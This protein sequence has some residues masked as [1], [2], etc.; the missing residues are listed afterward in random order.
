MN[1]FHKKITSPVGLLT[2]VASDEALVAIL[3]DADKPSRIRPAIGSIDNRHPILNDAERQLG[4]YFR[5]EREAFELP[6]DPAGTDF[7]KRVWLA[8]RKIPYGKTVSYAD[9]A[10]KIGSPKSSRAVGGATGRNP[11]SIVVPCHRVVGSDGSL[12]GFG[13]GLDNKVTLLALEQPSLLNTRA[14]A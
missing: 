7:Q 6:L 1:L 14:V 5:N 13:G 9:I 8:L 11:I 2:L 10:A 3:W 12:T 4:E